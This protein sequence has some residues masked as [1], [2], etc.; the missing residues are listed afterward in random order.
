MGILSIIIG[1]VT[2]LPNL[3]TGMENAFRG[4]P[5]SGSAKWIGVE[6]ALS[7]TI[8]NVADTI[9]KAAPAGSDPDKIAAAVA[10]YTK[11]SND[12]FVL[13]MNETGQFPLP[14]A[15]NQ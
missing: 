2:S 6:T 8:Q 5:K 3:I 10:K 4:V 9:V 12:A 1:I 14:P 7:S 11:A 13:L 15:A